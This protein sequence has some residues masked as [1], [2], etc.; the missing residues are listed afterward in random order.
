[1]RS[2]PHVIVL[3]G[4]SSSGKSALSAA[5]VDLLP[6]TWLRLSVDTLIDALPP[7]FDR[8][9][10]GLV[11]RPD[12]TVGT[13]PEWRR[14]EH[15]WMGGVATIAREVPVV[16]EDGFLSGPAAQDRWRGALEGL[17]VLWVG[18]RCD[19]EVAEARERARGDRVV[20]M[21]RAQALAVHE[22][23]YYDLE[24][25]TARSSP[26]GAAALVAEQV[27]GAPTK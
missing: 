18:V 27:R 2:G 5:L 16:V 12:G 14:V 8:V 20:G 23:I 7:G 13:G 6:G 10:G 22:G 4:G 24:V 19:P 26:R 1:M 11:L 21:A 17:D 9:E 25:D 3:N 15:A